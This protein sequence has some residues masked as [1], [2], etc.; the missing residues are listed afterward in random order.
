VTI[1]VSTFMGVR[2]E[3]G[4]NRQITDV[5]EQDEECQPDDQR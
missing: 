5:A 2:R 3:H 1:I 4:T